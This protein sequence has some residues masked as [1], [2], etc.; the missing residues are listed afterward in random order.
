MVGHTGNLNAA[1]KACETVDQCAGEIID[2]ALEN[3][4]KI[5]VI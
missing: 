3:Q 2:V 5:I 1:I 4:Y